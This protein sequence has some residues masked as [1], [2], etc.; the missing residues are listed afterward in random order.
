MALEY[1]LAMTEEPVEREPVIS[2]YDLLVGTGYLINFL[3]K[4]SCLT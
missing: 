4:Y 2:M 1:V 3:L